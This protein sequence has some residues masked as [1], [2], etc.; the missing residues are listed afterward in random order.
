VQ[1][2]VA[3]TYSKWFMFENM[4]FKDSFMCSP[5]LSYREVLELSRFR[6]GCHPCVPVTAGRR[7]KVPY[8]ERLCQLCPHSHAAQVGHEQ[9]IL[10]ECGALHSVRQRHNGFLSSLPDGLSMA[11][12]S[13]AEDQTAMARFCLDCIHTY[14]SF[15]QTGGGVPPAQTEHNDQ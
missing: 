6:L 4:A 3:C 10:L 5:D 15:T 13:N 11:S 9:H 8:S 14:E 1:H 2:R 12:L 7:N